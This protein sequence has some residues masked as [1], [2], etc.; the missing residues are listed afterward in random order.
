[1]DCS[2][3]YDAIR[4]GDDESVNR[5][6]PKLQ[7]VLNRFLRTTM[8][9]DVND[10]KDCVQQAFLFTIEK[11]RTDQIRDPDSL[12]FYLM[13]ACRN[14]YLRMSQR[15]DVSI[16]DSTFEYAVSPATQI[17][18]L[19]SEEKKRILQE[20]LDQLN[21]GHRSFIDFWLKHPRTEA[22]VVSRKFHISVNNVWTRKHR[23]IKLLSECCKKKSEE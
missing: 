15:Q 1:M 17:K 18:T 19:I 5:I 12:F 11:I 14:H 3:L 8:Q 9:A 20:C 6:I 22:S 23:I 4:S 16:E 13:R 21:A 7:T 10:A 2:E